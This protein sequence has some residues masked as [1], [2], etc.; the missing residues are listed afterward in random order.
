MEIGGFSI[1]VERSSAGG[2]AAVFAA[3]FFVATFF[4]VVFLAVAFFATVVARLRVAFFLGASPDDSMDGS[5]GVSP[6][7]GVDSLSEGSM[8]EFLMHTVSCMWRGN[9]VEPWKGN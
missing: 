1:G 4:L 3:T 9:R 7:G 2:F 5:I 8:K 6:E